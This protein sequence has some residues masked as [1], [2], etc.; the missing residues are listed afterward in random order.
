MV[1][2]TKTTKTE[3][4]TKSE[5]KLSKEPYDAAIP[6]GFNFDTFKALK[7]KN[8]KD[9]AL[10]YEHRAFEMKFKA[11]KFEAQAEEIRK[12]GSPSERR[13]KKQIIKLQSK[14]DELK[15]QLSAQGI[16]VEALLAEKK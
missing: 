5:F 3:K 9:E 16:D 8:F 13:K 14:M 10:Y 1:K 6:K 4:V 11:E 15:E 2:T 7:K 12:L